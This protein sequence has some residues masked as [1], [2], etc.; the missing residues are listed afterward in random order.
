MGL[1]M[2]VQV[3]LSYYMQ[4]EADAGLMVIDDN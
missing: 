2:S 3:T 4:E 1:Q